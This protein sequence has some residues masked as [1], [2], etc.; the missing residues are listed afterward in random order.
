MEKKKI[1]FENNFSPRDSLV[2]FQVWLVDCA[3]SPAIGASK[4]CEAVEYST[5]TKMKIIC[6][7]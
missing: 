6:N 7:E 3:L 5:K 1:Y 2:K 4:N